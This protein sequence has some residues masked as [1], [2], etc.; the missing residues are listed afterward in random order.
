MTECP[1]GMSRLSGLRAKAPL[2]STSGVCW[3]HC[4]KYKRPVTVKTRALESSA[5]QDVI[6]G[7]AIFG[8][9][10]TALYSGLKKDPV[11]C[12][13]CQGTGGCQCFACGGEGLKDP[14]NKSEVRRNA[15]RDVLG[16]EINPRAC[17]VC[18]G[19]GMVLCS[20][21]GGSGFQTGL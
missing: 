16:R 12:S 11:P 9:V 6:V 10:G 13:L 21:C 7:G 20:K 5:L 19:S 1:I 15:K 14:L 8:A 17:R 2:P 4:V 3:P 18:G